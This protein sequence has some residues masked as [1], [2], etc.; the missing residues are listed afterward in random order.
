[1]GFDAEATSLRGSS[2]TQLGELMPS[3]GGLII[4]ADLH[5]FKFCYV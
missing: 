2:Q 5:V 1:M 4:K 3:G